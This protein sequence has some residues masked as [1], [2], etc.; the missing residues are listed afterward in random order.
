M[1]NI[2]RRD[3]LADLNRQLWEYR[4]RVFGDADHLFER[5]SV[6]PS[7][8]P[9]FVREEDKNVIVRPGASP[10]EI[11]KVRSMIA[12]NARH[13]WFG[14]MRSSQA[15]AQSVFANLWYL[16]KLNVLAGLDTDDGG[17]AFFETGQ[18]PTE[19]LLEYPVNYLGEIEQRSTSVDLFMVGMTRVAVECKFSEAGVGDCSRPK[20]RPGH[21]AYEREH[22]DGS[23]TYQRGRTERCSLT[24]IRVRYW[25]YIPQLFDWRPDVDHPR[26]PIRYTYQLVRNVLAACVRG[27][28]VAP[29]GAHALVLYDHRN[30]AFQPGG[31]GMIAF[32]QVVTALRD[33]SLLRRCSW[34]RLLARLRQDDSLDWLTD[35]VERKYGL[36]GRDVASEEAW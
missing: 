13:R 3:Y 29:N 15:L 21:P 35:A 10:D 8:R 14:S 6:E 31:D 28:V 5:T 27:D 20:L 36:S 26:C 18:A 33:R 9:V 7:R 12:V 24:S 25:E 30:P 4:R 32:K 16:G 22:C 11:T 23:Y 34:Q 19:V 2:G 1:S 17:V